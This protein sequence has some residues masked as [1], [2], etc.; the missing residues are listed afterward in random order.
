[1]QAKGRTTK[2]IVTDQVDGRRREEQYFIIRQELQTSEEDPPS[3][4]HFLVVSEWR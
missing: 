2:P 4:R 1:M 3:T